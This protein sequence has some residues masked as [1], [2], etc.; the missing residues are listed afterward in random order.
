MTHAEIVEEVARALAPHHV[1]MS[2]PITSDTRLDTELKLDS[3]DTVELCMAVGE[4]FDVPLEPGDIQ[5]PTVG[6][7]AEL[8]ESRAGARLL[9]AQDPAF[10]SELL[11]NTETLEQQA[12]AAPGRARAYFE[13][14]PEMKD[15]VV[16]ANY[17]WRENY[18]ANP[19]AHKFPTAERTSCC[20]WCGRSREEV[21]HDELPAGCAQRPEPPDTAG[22]I[23]GEEESVFALMKRAETLVPKLL[24]KHGI[25][26]ATLFLLHSTHGIDPDMIYDL[27]GMRFEDEV[28][29][30]YR[31]LQQEDQEKSRQAIKRQEIKVVNV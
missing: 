2:K 18:Q 1:D 31:R 13:Q 9:R 30:D 8:I 6:R 12:F 5:P 16:K 15:W 22:I 4:E 25:K 21:R 19:L 28:M 24:D 26:G 23:K 29:A 7:V 14:H 3:L 27:F 17:A 11:P 10:L 20:V